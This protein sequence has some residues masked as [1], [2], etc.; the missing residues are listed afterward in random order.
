ME[1]FDFWSTSSISTE[2]L[3]NNLGEI[4]SR[5]NNLKTKELEII[6]EYEDDFWKI[7]DNINNVANMKFDVLLKNKDH[8]TLK[9]SLK[10]WCI[11]QLEQKY[12]IDFI[13][14]KINS[15][16][17][18]F[19]ISNAF[20][21][22]FLETFDKNYFDKTYAKSTLNMKAAI[23]CDFFE[24][25]DFRIN[26]GYHEL[27]FKTYYSTLTS[28]SLVRKIPSSQDILKFSL[29]VED[30]FNS[31]LSIENYFKYY[32][33]Y[34][35]WN[36]TNII[37]LRSREFC[38]I[39]SDPLTLTED[40]Y[41]IELPRLKNRYSRTLRY[42]YILIK[43]SLAQ[44]ILEYS[45]KSRRFG[46]S[47]TLINYLS[48]RYNSSKEELFTKKKRN[49]D[50]FLYGDFS[51]ILDSFYENVVIN[52]YGFNIEEYTKITIKG[53]DKSMT[54]KIRPNDTRHFAF[55]NLML[56]GYHP[57][58]IAR[59]GGHNSIYS[60]YVYHSHLEYW[61]DS[62]LVNLLMAQ[63][64]TLNNISNHFFQEILFKQK[65]YNPILKEEVV[66]I[67]LEIGFCIDPNQN[68]MVDE[69]YLCEH[70]RITK[71]DYENNFNQLNEMV[72]N[73]ES[74]LKKLVRQ[75][76]SLQEIAIS[77]KKDIIY[78][79]ENSTFNYRLVENANEVKHA[80]YQLFQLK[81]KVNGYEK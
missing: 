56:Q 31:E 78:S 76:L 68:C 60:Q 25:S 44:S 36:L 16:T 55:L 1:N 20:D 47:K 77:N 21:L 54:R 29:I 8:N 57:S 63:Q 38:L 64:S 34:L 75:L 12:S 69:H 58:E 26:D 81:E 32:P 30:Y 61:V 22:K 13:R 5:F 43:N 23:L 6:G 74:I 72:S 51:S 14:F 35:W 45:R 39:K 48:T 28:N 27:I 40:G 7:I 17:A 65:I 59:L 41:I 37:P 79:S 50:S 67:P 52:K 24:Y 18:A 46:K 66:K 4:R 80:L 15:V 62:D 19:K 11:L 70:W 10:S 2:Y 49:Q 42:D 9:K 3:E 53:D 73:Q 71:E 33:I